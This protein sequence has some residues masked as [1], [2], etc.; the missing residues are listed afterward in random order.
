MILFRSVQLF[1]DAASFGAIGFGLLSG[2]VM[3]V[4]SEV[5]VTLPPRA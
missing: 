2:S 3:A 5:W 4:G 1:E